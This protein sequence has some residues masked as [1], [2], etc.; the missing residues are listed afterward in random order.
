MKISQV[1]FRLEVFALFCL[2][3]TLKL[4]G[5]IAWSWWGVFMPIILTVSF[6]FVLG[7]IVILCAI[8]TKG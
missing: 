8:V 7:V 2:F 6:Y 1:I 4:C 3:L 5:V